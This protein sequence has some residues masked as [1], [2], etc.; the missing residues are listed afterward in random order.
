[1]DTR[2]REELEPLTCSLCRCQQMVA[3]DVLSFAEPW[4]AASHHPPSYFIGIRTETPHTY[5]RCE[6][7]I[8]F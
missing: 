4:R 3:A 2:R 1:M 5:K 8:T 7:L 6:L